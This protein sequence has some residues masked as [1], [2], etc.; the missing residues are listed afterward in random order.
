[1]KNTTKLFALVLVLA[2]AVLAFAGCMGEKGS[3]TVT[4]VIAGDETNEYEVP[5][6]ELE[7]ATVHNALSYLKE[8]LGIAYEVSG[9]MVT[10][11]G[12]LKN[13][14]AAYKWIYFWTSVAKDADVSEWASTIE[15]A[16]RN[17]TSS[18]V[19]AMEMSVVDEAIIYIGYYE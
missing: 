7:S 13:D 5:I 19:S 1:M 2:F 11:A 4:I 10:E 3:G 8:K 16:G 17:L 18:G 15:F 12:T 6:D 14:D 9:T